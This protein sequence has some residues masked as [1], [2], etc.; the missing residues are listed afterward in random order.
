[1]NVNANYDGIDLPAF[2]AFNGTAFIFE[3]KSDIDFGRIFDIYLII[4]DAFNY[5]STKFTVK[6]N[7]PPKFEV[8]LKDQ[9]V[10]MN[11]KMYYK[12]P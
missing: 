9:I 6:I 12:L 5:I 8:P 3:P 4:D 10:E 2:M 11:K 1:M 7:Y